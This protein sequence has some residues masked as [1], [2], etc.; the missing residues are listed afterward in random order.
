M[1]TRRE[2][3]RTSG[4]ALATGA[5]VGGV[6]SVGAAAA[7]AI[8]DA[9][10][11]HV[12]RTY[13][14]DLLNRYKPRLVVRD[15]GTNTPT[16][17]YSFVA[18]STEFNDT[19]LVYWASYPFQEGVALGYD[20]HWGD[21][22]PIYVRI[23]EDRDEILD[24]AF[25]A[26]HWLR[27]WNPSPP[28]VLGDTEGAVH[29]TFHVVNPW[30]HYFLTTEEGVDVDLE[31]LSDAELQAWLDNGWDEAVHL[32]SVT[33]P[34][35]MTGADGRTDWWL[36]TVG[37]FSYEAGLRRYVYPLLYGPGEGVSLDDLD[38]DF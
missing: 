5:L 1:P 22:E 30:H 35:V 23:N 25:S 18:R 32:P 34:W 2:Y 4:K 11:E 3:L 28:T 20:S 8:D 13:E 33:Q 29:P 27:G 16:A 21:H 31:H 24:V 7:N 26:Y 6:F 14:P 10:P 12:T 17:L 15:L 19:V 37:S 36:D 38:V 9:T